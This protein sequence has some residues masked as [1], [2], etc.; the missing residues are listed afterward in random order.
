M[1]AW[2]LQLHFLFISCAT[3]LP[4]LLTVLQPREP[5]AAL[6]GPCFF[7]PP[8]LWDQHRSQHSANKLP[9]LLCFPRCFSVINITDFKH[10]Y[11]ICLLK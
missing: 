8:H 4:T 6:E 2:P 11:T 7:V 1:P 9:H 3:I 10:I 5:Q